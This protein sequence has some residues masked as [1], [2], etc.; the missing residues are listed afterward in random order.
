MKLFRFVLLALLCAAPASAQVI[1]SPPTTGGG[2]GTVVGGAC[3]GAPDQMTT[4]ISST[5]VPTCSKVTSAFVDATVYALGAAAGTPSSINLA[6]GTALPIATGV[7]GL[8]A[9][10]AAVLATFSSANLRTAV[11]DE[12]GTGALLFAGGNI[13]AATGTSL[14]LSGLGGSGVR[15]LQTDNVGAISVAAAGCGGG[16]ASTALD[17][18]AAVNI[19]TPLLAQTGV[20]LGSTTKPFRDV[21]IFG[22][23]TYGSTY[24][25]LTGTFTGNRVITLP[26]ATATLLY[27]GGPGGTPSSITLSGA[28]SASLPLA[29]V[30]G[31][32]SNIAAYLAAGTIASFATAAGS[33]NANCVIG[34]PDGSAGNLA[35]VTLSYGYLPQAVPITKLTAGTTLAAFGGTY[36]LNFASPQTVV[37]PPV[38][39]HP[40]VGYTFITIAGSSTATI[41]G[42][43][44]ETLCNPAGCATT[45]TV[46][47]N[48]VMTIMADADAGYWRVVSQ[49]VTGSGAATVFPKAPGLRLTTQSGTCKSTTDRTAQG[50]IYYT[51]AGN[52]GGSSYLALYSGSAWVEFTQAELSLS[53]T[54][55]SGKNYDVWAC[56]NS[57]TPAISLSAAWTNDTTR[58][59][60][61]ALQDGFTVKSSDHTCLAVGAIRAS[62]SNVTEDSLGGSTTQVGGK[63]FV[64]NR[65]VQTPS[66]AS[67]IDTTDSWAYTTDTWR[68]ANAASGNKVEYVTGD[69]GT[70]IEA[71]VLST[72]FIAS[73]SVVGARV[74]VGVD[75][76]SVASGRISQAFASTTLISGTAVG[77]FVGYPGLG[78]HAINWIERGGDTNSSFV[79]D[80]AGA[81]TQSGLGIVL[82]N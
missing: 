52:C 30:G 69:A 81:A 21:F 31:L 16:G 11:T 19:N 51:P 50:T 48:E 59:D 70:Q 56:Y 74:A 62:G 77:R 12:S 63:R 57:G 73:E 79:G 78:Y 17:N 33:Q 22:S 58:A 3:P 49:A 66:T 28:V 76:T 72:V 46:A 35:C 53:L 25:R 36:Q 47:A 23:G 43:S 38:A 32:A 42:N 15:C 71:E 20:D 8:G 67:V 5:G 55:T 60:A 80:D 61:V 1:V 10:V 18:L 29:A 54:A 45:K 14:S 4:S 39:T 7:S 40:G 27:D 41:D 75:S 68:Q 2:S 82:A 64:W 65:W 44:S 13:G 37:L 26:N 9:N 6:N 24:G 34:A